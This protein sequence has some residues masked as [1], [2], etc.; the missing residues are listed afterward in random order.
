MPL[1]AFKRSEAALQVAVF[2]KCSKFELQKGFLCS[3]GMELL[4]SQHSAAVR[5]R[6][7]ARDQPFCRF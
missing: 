3:H 6:P 5:R 7:Y 4:C 1:L 2:P